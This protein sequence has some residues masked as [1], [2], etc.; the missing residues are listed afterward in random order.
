M[1]ARTVSRTTALAGGSRKSV[2][3]FRRD[4]AMSI[5][6]ARVFRSRNWLRSSIRC[7]ENS[8]GPQ[9][10]TVII[11]AITAAAT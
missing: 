8:I 2:L 6:I 1:Y 5:Q 4:S 9:L 3:K 11:G 7:S 10:T